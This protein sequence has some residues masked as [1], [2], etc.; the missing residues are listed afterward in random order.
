MAEKKPE[1]RVVSEVCSMCGL[2]WKR[3]GRT[4]TTETCIRLLA[5]DLA[6]ANERANRVTINFPPVIYPRPVQY[7]PPVWTLTGTASPPPRADITY[8]ISQ[9]N[10][11]GATPQLASSVPHPIAA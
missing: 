7:Y 3:H 4:P 10:S 2:D 1:A 6:A 8:C 9:G 11:S 5:S